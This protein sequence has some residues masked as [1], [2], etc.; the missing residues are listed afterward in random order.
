MHSKPF[1]QVPQLSSQFLVVGLS[2]VSITQT[3]DSIYEKVNASDAIAH[4]EAEGNHENYICF[5]I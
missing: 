1:F 4:R 3:V 2:A 5:S